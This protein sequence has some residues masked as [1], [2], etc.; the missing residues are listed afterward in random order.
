MHRGNNLNVYI[1]FLF[2]FILIFYIFNSLIPHQEK[3]LIASYLRTF[4]GIDWKKTA[5]FVKY[6][7]E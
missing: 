6:P 1:A 3:G 2:N 7:K 4:A 5:L